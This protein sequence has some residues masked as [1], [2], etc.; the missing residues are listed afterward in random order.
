MRINHAH[1]RICNEFATDSPLADHWPNDANYPQ[2]I[3]FTR[4]QYNACHNDNYDSGS[5]APRNN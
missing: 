5:D 4:A 3:P 1:V 2:K